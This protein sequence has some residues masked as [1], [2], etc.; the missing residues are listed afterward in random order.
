MKNLVKM[1]SEFKL[2]FTITTAI[3]GLLT[4]IVVGYAATGSINASVALVCIFDL[5]LSG[6]HLNL[7][8]TMYEAT[9]LKKRERYF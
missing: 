8:V 4:A 6:L 9:S 3:S 5:A 1:S 7:T 2:F